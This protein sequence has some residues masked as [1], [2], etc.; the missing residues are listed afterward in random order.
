MSRKTKRILNPNTKMVG[1]KKSMMTLTKPL[2]IMKPW[3][4]KKK[5]RRKRRQRKM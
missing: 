1:R 5:R 3:I 4:M 2:L